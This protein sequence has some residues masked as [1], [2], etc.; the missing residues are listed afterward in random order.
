MAQTQTLRAPATHKE[1]IFQN[2]KINCLP[3]I[4]PGQLNGS[5]SVTQPYTFQMKVM[6]NARIV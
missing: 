5:L 6:T 3:S 2:K 4:T 1:G